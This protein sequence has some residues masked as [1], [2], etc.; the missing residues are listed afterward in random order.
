MYII[1]YCF[2]FTNII[3]IILW[4]FNFTLLNL[5]FNKF[6][7]I[8]FTF[9]LKLRLKILQLYFVCLL[10]LLLISLWLI[11]FWFRKILPLNR[12]LFIFDMNLL[13]SFYLSIVY[14]IS[15]TWIIFKFICKCFITNSRFPFFLGYLHFN[16]FY[17]FRHLFHRCY[18]WPFFTTTCCTT[19][20]KHKYIFVILH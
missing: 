19:P 15:F 9:R 20:F 3:F 1:I 2:T 17:K 14:I 16:L 8:S 7:I 18:W 13:V 12:L 4:F 10:F 6:S 5:F 11:L